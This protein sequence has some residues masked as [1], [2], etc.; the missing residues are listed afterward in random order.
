MKS[1]DNK[2]IVSTYVI[3]KDGN[4]TIDKNGDIFDKKRNEIVNYNYQ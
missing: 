3:T 2:S 4:Y 1:E